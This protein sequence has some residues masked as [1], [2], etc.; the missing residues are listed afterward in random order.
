MAVKKKAKVKTKKAAKKSGAVAK[1]MAI[2]KPKKK[3]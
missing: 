1:V 2:V 3:K